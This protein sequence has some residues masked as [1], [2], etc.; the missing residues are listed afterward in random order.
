MLE[1]VSKVLTLTTSES[2]TTVSERESA[3]IIFIFETAMYPYTAMSSI[4][5]NNP[6]YDSV[7]LGLAVTWRDRAV[8]LAQLRT[9]RTDCVLRRHPNWCARY[10]G[11]LYLCCSLAPGR[12]FE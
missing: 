4:V 12:T 9:T 11:I 10:S 5:Y 7:F 6:R 8:V 3:R 1:K 2:L